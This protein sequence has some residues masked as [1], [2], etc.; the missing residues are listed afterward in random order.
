M[1]K[2]PQIHLSKTMAQGLFFCRGSAGASV[3][4]SSA[5]FLRLFAL[6]SGAFLQH[7]GDGFDMVVSAVTDRL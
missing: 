5:R 6:E 3:L 7:R 4:L 2:P 1:R